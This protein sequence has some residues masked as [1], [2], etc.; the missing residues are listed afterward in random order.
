MKKSVMIA[1]ALVLA[2]GLGGVSTLAMADDTNPPHKISI[3]LINKAAWPLSVSNTPYPASLTLNDNTLLNTVLPANKSGTAVFALNPSAGAGPASGNYTIT[4]TPA[5]LDP[6]NAKCD[7]SFSFTNVF[8][9]RPVTCSYLHVT[10]SDST[11]PG[12][13]KVSLVYGTL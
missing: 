2:I 10:K 9:L 13:L 3:T 5:E 12:M 6:T 1:S 4:I 8:Q 7:I 11:I